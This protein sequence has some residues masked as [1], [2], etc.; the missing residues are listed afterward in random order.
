MHGCVRRRRALGSTHGHSGDVW[1]WA[2]R[3]LR[4]PALPGR[5]RQR[6]VL[7]AV[8]PCWPAGAPGGSQS[9]LSYGKWRRRRTRQLALGPLRRHQDSRGCR[10]ACQHPPTRWPVGE[11]GGGALGADGPSPGT[12]EQQEAWAP[13]LCG[14]HT[15]ALARQ[16]RAGF[17][18]ADESPGLAPTPPGWGGP[19]GTESAQGS[20]TSPAPTP[21]WAWPGWV[22]RAGSGEELRATGWVQDSHGPSRAL[23]TLARGALPPAPGRG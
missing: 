14:H 22:G 2:V 1:L 23:R 8:W 9:S 16:E 13:S 4:G 3:L 11:A 17:Q 7:P 21:E 12:L 20:R 19:P 5:N 6:A 18:Q 15:F 10:T